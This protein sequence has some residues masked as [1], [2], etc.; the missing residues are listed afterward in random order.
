MMMRHISSIF[1]FKL[2]S[3]YKQT[4]TLKYNRYCICNINFDNI[5]IQE[6]FTR[7]FLNK[8]CNVHVCCFFFNTCINNE[9]YERWG[10]DLVTWLDCENFVRRTQK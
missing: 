6:C 5:Y 3:I 1:F 8:H 9:T 7:I 2:F 4:F 10:P